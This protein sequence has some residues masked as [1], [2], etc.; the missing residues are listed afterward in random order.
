MRALSERIK[1]RGKEETGTIS[2][3]KKDKGEKGSENRRSDKSDSLRRRMRGQSYGQERKSSEKG[4][5]FE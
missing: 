4:K 1:S 3:R 2:K 5:E